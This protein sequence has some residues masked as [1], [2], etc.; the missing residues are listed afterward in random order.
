MTIYNYGYYV[1]STGRGA[2]INTAQLGAMFSAMSTASPV[3]G[4]AF[5]PQDNFP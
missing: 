2:T 1:G 5:I 4:L 3:G